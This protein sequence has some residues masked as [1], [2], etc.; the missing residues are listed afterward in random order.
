MFGTQTWGGRMVGADKSTQLWGH[1]VF[2]Y[3][4]VVLH[5]R[6]TACASQQAAVNHYS[7][8]TFKS[9]L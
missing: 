6:S 8:V 5:D 4:S 7:T 9:R 2:N 3:L 1:P